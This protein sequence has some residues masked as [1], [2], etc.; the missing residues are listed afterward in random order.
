MGEAHSRGGG[1]GEGEQRAGGGGGPALRAPS[2]P[3]MLGGGDGS[4]GGTGAS[5][6]AEAGRE[7]DRRTW[8]PRN[9]FQGSV[10]TIDP[11]GSSVSRETTRFRCV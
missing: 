11:Q 6:L 3:A 5:H 10:D 8:L 9:C 2:R 4:R 1:H 7:T